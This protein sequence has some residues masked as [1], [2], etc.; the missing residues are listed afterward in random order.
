[1][2]LRKSDAIDYGRTFLEFSTGQYSQ[3]SLY[4]SV[5]QHQHCKQCWMRNSKQVQ[6]PCQW[7][8]DHPVS[9]GRRTM[10]TTV[11]R[12]ETTKPPT[13]VY[14]PFSFRPP[15]LTMIEISLEIPIR[16]IPSRT[17]S[18]GPFPLPCA[19]QIMGFQSSGTG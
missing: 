7:A 17:R 11:Q 5:A 13:K 19:N 10:V 14:N 3:H 16:R 1:M 8:I 2:R 9:D 15:R 18:D 6:I 12:S 4:G